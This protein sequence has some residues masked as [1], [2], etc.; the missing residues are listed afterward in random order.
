V[1]NDIEFG[2]YR[3]FAAESTVSFDDSTPPPN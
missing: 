1:V 3:K 2:G